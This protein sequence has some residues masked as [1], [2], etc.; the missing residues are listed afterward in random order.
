MQIAMNVEAQAIDVPTGV[1]TIAGALRRHRGSRTRRRRRAAWP[2]V[3]APE[4]ERRLVLAYTWR[5]TKLGHQQLGGPPTAYP[6]RVE[7][8]RRSRRLRGVAAV[9]E[10]QPLP[11]RP[12]RVG[13]RWAGKIA[14]R[15]GKP[16]GPR[17]R[18][19]DHRDRCHPRRG[20]SCTRACPAPVGL[21]SSRRRQEPLRLGEPDRI[22]DIRAAI[23]ANGGRLL[24][25]IMRPKGFES[26]RRYGVRPGQA[27]AQARSLK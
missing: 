22:P 2:S 24:D 14:G 15:D 11:E 9:A 20:A 23:A 16:Q 13:A 3:E 25:F 10:L 27:R 5:D 19:A 26:R 1:G 18:R 21:A 12:R 8:Q 17:A 7:V 4:L 6:P